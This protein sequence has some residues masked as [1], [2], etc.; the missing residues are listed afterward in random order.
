MYLIG[1]LDCSVMKLIFVIVTGLK[2][3]LDFMTL[4][5]GILPLNPTIPNF[6]DA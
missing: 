4:L 5:M 3:S 1:L 2:V 6:L